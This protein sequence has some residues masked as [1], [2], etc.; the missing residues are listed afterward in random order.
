MAVVKQ[1]ERLTFSDTRERAG[2]EIHVA[3]KISD[4][5]CSSALN[6]RGSECRVAQRLRIEH[7]NPIGD[8]RQPSLA[9]SR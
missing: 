1:R 3:E 4:E 6:A 5:R 9:V 7:I 8:D 2:S